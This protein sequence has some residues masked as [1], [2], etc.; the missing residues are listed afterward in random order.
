M[1]VRRRM[2]FELEK[3]R[4]RAHILEGLRVALKHLDEIIELI[5][6]SPDADAARD[7]MMKRYKLSEIQAQAI[8]DMQL[9]RLAALERKK[10]EDEYKEIIAQIKVL[11]G[12]L[13]SPAKMRTVVA[14]ELRQVKE[15]YGDRRRTQIARLGA[16]SKSLIP[17]LTAAD[18]LPEREIWV[19]ATT[20]GLVSRTLDEKPPRI[21]GL[22][23]PRFFTAG[24]YARH[25]IPGLIPGRSGWH[26]GRGSA[27]SRE[28]TGWR[29]T[30]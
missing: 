12:L 22:A 21:S 16:G 27:G 5:R 20:E 11:E 2:E 9:R 19:T 29:P 26:P 4:A 1:V 23:A 8:L 25:I 3:A 10:I 7:R 17:V 18:L 24:Q 6:K 13:H 15:A 30:A 14:D 28:S